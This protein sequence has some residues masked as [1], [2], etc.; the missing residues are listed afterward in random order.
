MIAAKSVDAINRGDYQLVMGEI[1]LALNTMNAS[2]RVSQCPRPEEL[3]HALDADLPEPRLVPV[4][5]KTWAGATAR[6]LPALISS[7][8]FRLIVTPEPHE[9]PAS[10]AVPIGSLVV[11]EKDGNLVLRS[12][13][14]RIS[15]DIIEA[16]GT[17]LSSVIGNYFHLLA[18]ASHTP[19]VT[20]DRVTVCRESWKFS[21]GDLSFAFEKDE[22][23]RFLAA[24]R[25]A[26]SHDLPRFVFVKVPVEVKP[27][28]VDFDSPVYVDLL[29]K[30]VRRT[31]E[32]GRP[33][34][35]VS[36]TEMFPRADETWLPDA[37]GKH[38]TSELRI[39]AVDLQK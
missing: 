17:A 30:S 36:V 24:R 19:R 35:L 14:G 23:E 31:K 13:D 25:F 15:Y 8:D 34:A 20:I 7:K 21:P 9:V 32:K 2:L 12:R 26:R 10:Q 3:I 37:E 6:T 28:Y 27:F 29:A 18:P 5:P 4:N 1:H 33:D 39:I 22:A 11:E 16:F 38:Y